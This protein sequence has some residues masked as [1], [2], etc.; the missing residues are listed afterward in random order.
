MSIV[1]LVNL[2]KSALGVTQTCRLLGVAKSSYYDQVKRSPKRALRCRALVSQIRAVFEEHLGN[3]GSPRIYRD[4][5]GKGVRVSRRRVAS[6]MREYRLVAR[7]KRRFRPM[8]TDSNHDGPIA[9]NLLQQDFSASAPNRIWV[10]DIT[11]VATREGWLYL[12]V[13]IDVFSRRV[14]GWATSASPKA[15]LVVQA[16]GRA[17]DLRKPKPGLIV[18]SD[19]G[20]QYAS[21]L[22]RD[23]MTKAK[24]VPSMS[25]TGNCYDNAMAESFFSTLDFELRR[26]MDFHT[27]RQAQFAL[28]E[29]IENYYNRKRMHSSVDYKSPVGYEEMHMAA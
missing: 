18:H 23:E 25:R 3:Y 26:H 21:K 20:S 29:F 1:K 24:A 17:V 4:L 14:V 2:G 11:F 5:R 16:L 6:L 22:Y 7:Q 12:A 9:P 15:Q 13:I 8:T 19:R 10:G 28:A 27:H